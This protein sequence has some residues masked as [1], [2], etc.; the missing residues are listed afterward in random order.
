MLGSTDRVDGFYIDDG[1]KTVLEFNGCLH[2][3]HTCLDRDTKHPLNGLTMEELYQKTLERR[4]YIENQGYDY[5]EKWEC[6]F[7]AELKLNFKMKSFVSSLEIIPPLV[8]RDAFCGGRTNATRLFYEAGPGEKIKYVDFTSL[9][10]YI[11]KY[12]K[13]PIGHPTIITE[14]FRDVSQ[15]EGLVK[16]KVLPPR[17]LYHPVLPYKTC[18]HLMFPL[19]AACS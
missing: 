16:C 14:N 11:N 4:R 8:P 6:D 2:H 12:G 1:V 9:Y 13:Y 3:G 7:D 15:Y 19:C 18:G 17:G 10:P 5:V